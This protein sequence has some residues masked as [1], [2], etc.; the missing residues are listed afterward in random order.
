MSG[1]TSFFSAGRSC[2]DTRPQT[3]IEGLPTDM[4]FSA[5]GTILYD[6]KLTYKYLISSYRSVTWQTEYLG[7]VSSGELALA[8]DG[9]IHDADKKQGGFYSQLDLAVR[10]AGPVAGGRAV[11][12]ARPEFVHHRRRAAAARQD[13]ATVHGHARVQPHRVLQ[14]PAPVR[15]TTGPATSRG[16]QKDVHEVLLQVNIAVGP[17]GAHSFKIA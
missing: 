15:T 7:R 14:I 10:R 11:R 17:H 2:T 9:L 1:I 6:A 16:S 5:P 13:A 8:S 4:A 3:R 12:P